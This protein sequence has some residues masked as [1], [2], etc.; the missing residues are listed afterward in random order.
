MG[1][2]QVGDAVQANRGLAGSRS[3]LD[4]QRLA[5]G[6]AHDV[7]L[8]GLDRGHDVAHRAG[9]GPLY[10]VQQNPADSGLREQPWL[11]V[12]AEGLILVGGELAAGEPEPAAQLKAHRLGRAGPVERPGNRRPPV[13]HH[14]MAVRIMDVP[15]AHVEPAP[16]DPLA[17][18]AV[19]R[20]AVRRGIV[21]PAEEQRRVRQVAERLRPAAQIRLEVFLG[22]RVTAQRPQR[23]HVFTHEPE[24]VAGAAQVSLFGAEDGVRVAASPAG[25][26]HE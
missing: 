6:R 11:F 21:E 25:R 2:Q 1:V 7:V 14:G 22:D 15:P 23:E 12:A 17:R 4:A 16:G 20:G 3:T 10:L 5:R 24:E 13:D 19:H 8:L 9:P 26:G 18:S